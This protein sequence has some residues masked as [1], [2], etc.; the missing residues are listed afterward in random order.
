[1]G[2]WRPLLAGLALLLVTGCELRETVT[3]PATKGT[4]SPFEA[5]EWPEYLERLA[6]GRERD[7]VILAYVPPANPI[8]L[9]TPAR[10]RATLSNLVF[11]QLGALQA[12][13][14]IGHLIVGWQCGGRRGM[15]SMTGELSGQG[16]SMVL[17]GWGVTPILST[18]LDG[19]IVSLADFPEH[20][21][22]ALVEGRGV[23]VASE[24]DRADCLAAREEVV[25]FETHPN[26]P[27]RKY[28][29]ILRPDRYEGGGCLSFA[30]HI[31]G[32]AGVMPRLL[33]LAR[34]D[35]PLRAA[36]L[37]VQTEAPAGVEV[38]TPPGGLTGPA[39]LARLLT[40]PWGDG[41]VVDEVTVF[42]GEAMMAAL[43]FAGVGVQ[44][45][46]DPRYSRILDR[47]DPVIG[48]AARYGLRWGYSYPVRRLADPDGVRAVILEKG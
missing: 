42:D 1:V 26:E 27:H 43:V 37:G 46:N 2:A 22:R 11:D 34:R 18:F 10:S 38:Y 7:Y 44:A 47:E 13:T 31:A 14:T 17:G 23:V 48:A 29:L 15:T 5:P 36:Q 3:H 45:P 30:A 40:E 39:P 19:E 8:D 9:T 6:L 12:G 32:E 16:K 41:P 35:V 28:S 25:R 20:Q 24:V 21:N 4:L 33:E